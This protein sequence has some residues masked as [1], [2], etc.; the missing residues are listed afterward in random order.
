[1]LVVR[2]AVS[3]ILLVEFAPLLASLPSELRHLY[4]QAKRA[5]GVQRSL[6]GIFVSDLGIYLMASWLLQT[7]Y[8]DVFCYFALLE[9]LGQRQREIERKQHQDSTNGNR[10]NTKDQQASEA[11]TSA[12]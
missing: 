4:Q 11:N 6:M 9:C 3:V 5:Q 1:M 12:M 10:Y 2:C 7:R 8:I